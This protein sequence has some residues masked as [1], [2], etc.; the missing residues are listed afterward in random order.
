MK[1]EGFFSDNLNPSIIST[2]DNA[3]D[4]NVS[5][6]NELTGTLGLNPA[7]DF[8]HSD[9]S[10]VDFSGSD[11]RGYDFTGANLCGAIG[12][13]VQWDKTTIFRQQT[14]ESLSL[15]L[16]FRTA[17]FLKNNPAFA[18][19]FSL[20]SN[21]YWADQILYIGNKIRTDNTE[22][23]RLFARKLLRETKSSVEDLICYT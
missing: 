6:F 19:E 3:I 18:N 21:A 16:K 7:S 9:L 12:I 5:N 10:N 2:I 4:W 13:G 20:L 17:N 22:K 15:R 8:R 23:M 1:I 14:S 11:I